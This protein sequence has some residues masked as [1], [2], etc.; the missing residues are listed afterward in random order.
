MIQ[1]LEP[2]VQLSCS[3]TSTVMWKLTIEIE[4]TIVFESSLKS[5]GMFSCEK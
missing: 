3:F 5:E 1:I 2:D 4:N